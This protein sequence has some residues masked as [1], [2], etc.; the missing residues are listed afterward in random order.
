MHHSASM[1]VI[2]KV[3]R[4]TGIGRQEFPFTYLEYPIFYARRKM[5]YYQEFITKVMDK[6]QVWKG[7]LLSIGGQSVLISHVLQ[8]MLIH[9]LS[10]VNPPNNVINKLH[11]IFAQFFW[12]SSIGGSSR[13]WASWNNLCMPCDEA[14]IGFRSLHDVSKALFY[15]LWWNFRTK[16]SLWSAFMSQKYCKKLNAVITGLGALY[17]LVPPEFGVDETVYNVYDVMDDSAWNADK[18][19]EILPEEF[20]EHILPHMKP[21]VVHDVLDKPQWMLETRGEFSVKSAWE[22]LRRRN[23]PANAYKKI[24]VKGLPFKIA[25]FMW[26]VWRNKLPLYDFFKRVGYLMASK[27]WCCAEPKEE[28]MQHLFFTSYTANRVWKYFL[29]HASIALDGITFHQTVTKC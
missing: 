23:K 21:P 12:S 4:I 6:I 5:D 14:A 18:I 2:T 22:Y 20:A 25:F 27:C 28:I 16:P 29:G 19:L 3:E 24:W 10:A 9:L 26:K 7:K 15:K 17:F 13:H 11:K 8:S 1:K